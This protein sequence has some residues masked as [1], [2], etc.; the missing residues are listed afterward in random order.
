MTTAKERQDAFRSTRRQ[1]DLE[2]QARQIPSR[3]KS[4]SDD[5]LVLVILN[6]NDIGNGA[7]GVL[8]AS[9]VTLGSLPDISLD[10]NVANGIGRA[11]LYINGIISGRVWVR[12]DRGDD[13]GPLPSG[14]RRSASA[15]TSISYGAGNITAYRWDY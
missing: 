3:F 2:R 4:A 5:V 13:V 7:K 15:I 11:H 12:H 8:Y 9:S 1:L 6:G 14:A 10:T